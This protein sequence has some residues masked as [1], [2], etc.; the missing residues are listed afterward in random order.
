[1][2]VGVLALGSAVNVAVFS[3]FVE[4]SLHANSEAAKTAMKIFLITR[5][6]GEKDPVI[7]MVA[8]TI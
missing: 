2:L 5:V 4:L 3:V 7:R 8:T 1:M 6:L